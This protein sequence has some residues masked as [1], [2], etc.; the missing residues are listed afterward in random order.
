MV[1]RGQLNMR[2]L[3]I[4]N[5]NLSCWSV[6]VSSLVVEACLNRSCDF[7]AA[8]SRRSSVFVTP[9]AAAITAVLPTLTLTAAS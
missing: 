6:F 9:S 8:L 1:L 3:S 7:A 2:V 4:A 5:F